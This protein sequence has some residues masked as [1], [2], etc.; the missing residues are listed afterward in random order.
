MMNEK[1]SDVTDFVRELIKTEEF[2]DE[3]FLSNINDAKEELRKSLESDEEYDDEGVIV[4]IGDKTYMDIKGDS[5]MIL[6]SRDEFNLLLRWDNSTS[7]D[8]FAINFGKVELGFQI[9]PK[10]EFGLLRDFVGFTLTIDGVLE[11]SAFPV[12]LNFASDDFYLS[13]DL[14]YTFE[15]L[16]IEGKEGIVRAMREIK[17]PR[18]LC[19]VIRECYI[20]IKSDDYVEIE[21]VEDRMNIQWHVRKLGGKVVES[22]YGV[23]KMKNEVQLSKLN[24]YINLI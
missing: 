15:V 23:Y 8:Q 9:Y 16:L 21:G 7:E 5:A 17:M 4:G 22:K 1:L 3:L 13:E 20:K 19:K 10:K 24:S 12:D 18:E 11:C 14:D 6:Q 2:E